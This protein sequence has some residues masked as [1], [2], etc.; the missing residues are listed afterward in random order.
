MSNLEPALVISTFKTPTLSIFHCLYCCYPSPSYYPAL[1]L[2][3]PLRYPFIQQL[4]VRPQQCAGHH[5][6][7]WFCCNE[8]VKWTSLLSRNLDPISERCLLIVLPDFLSPFSS[9]YSSYNSLNILLKYL[10][11][12]KLFS[13]GKLFSGLSDLIPSVFPPLSPRP[14]APSTLSLFQL[15]GLRT[16]CSLWLGSSSFISLCG[17]HP[18]CIQTLINITQESFPEHPFLHSCPSSHAI[19]WPL[20]ISFEAFTTAYHNIYLFIWIWINSFPLEY[21]LIEVKD[22][23]LSCSLFFFQYSEYCLPHDGHWIKIWCVN[24]LMN[25]KTSSIIMGKNPTKFGIKRTGL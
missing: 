25:E 20:F 3:S 21:K 6:W 4:P 24:E 16:H 10:C 9:V 15:P 23:S 22:F 7:C 8:L 13:C 17:L 2:A 12:I 14:S 19:P 1:P 18:H 11:K 5:S